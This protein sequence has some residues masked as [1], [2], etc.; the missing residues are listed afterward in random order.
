MNGTKKFW[1]LIAVVA[2]IGLV[3]GACFLDEDPANFNPSLTLKD[4][5][6]VGAD[7]QP[8]TGKKTGTGSG[9]FHS[10]PAFQLEF[11]LT[12]G[13]ITG[14]NNL[15]GTFTC[16]YGAG[17]F[18][19]NKAFIDEYTTRVISENSSDVETIS[20]ATRTLT[21]FKSAMNDAFSK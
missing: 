10:S 12:D 21:A 14:V 20:G 5:K 3:L 19:G 15:R 13:K 18:T 8:Y 6:W 17:S 2:V 7:G 11:D 4:G 9:D 16:S 1:V